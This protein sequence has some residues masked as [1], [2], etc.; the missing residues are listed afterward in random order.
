MRLPIRPP[1]KPPMTAPASGLPP[2]PLAMAAPATAPVPAPS[3]VPVPS[4]GPRPDSGSPAQA[5]SARPRPATAANLTAN[6]DT[7]MAT[8]GST[9]SG[10]PAMLGGTVTLS[11]REDWGKSPADSPRRQHQFRP[12]AAERRGAEF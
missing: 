1:S 12:Q 9:L 8:P 10:R 3:S 11:R 6:F 2:V 5:A 4:F 7:D